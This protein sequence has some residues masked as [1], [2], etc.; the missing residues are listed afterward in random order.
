MPLPVDAE[1]T[2]RRRVL[3]SG[4]FD[5]LDDLNATRHRSKPSCRQPWMTTS[6]GSARG[7]IRY[8]TV[9]WVRAEAKVASIIMA[10]VT[11]KALR[12]RN[13]VG[14]YAGGA[15]TSVYHDMDAH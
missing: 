1:P 9:S 8:R 14:R 2:A 5:I 3:D 13:R 10:V 15:E 6:V 7:N 11:S 12:D 4:M